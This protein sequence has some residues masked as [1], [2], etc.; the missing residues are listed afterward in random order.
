MKVLKRLLIRAVLAAIVLLLSWFFYKRDEQQQISPSARTY[1]DYVEICAN[2]LDDYT[3]QLSTYQEGKKMVGCTDWDELTAKIRLEAGINCGYAASRQTSEDLTD[4]R[5]K[6][7]DFAY[8]TAM[9]LETRILALE[10]PELAEILN[11][12][13]EKFEDQ[14]ETNYDSFSD[15]VKKR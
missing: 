6:V 3:N 2:I 5:T 1:D 11:A 7:Y 15:Q 8:S 13:S 12:A 9:A 14:A 10:N 4:Q